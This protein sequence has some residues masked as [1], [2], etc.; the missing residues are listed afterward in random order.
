MPVN[1]PLGQVTTLTQNQLYGH[2]A[3][4]GN[5]TI[6]AD[7]GTGQETVIN[8]SADKYS[9]LIAV[10]QKLYL[11]NGNKLEQIYFGC[12]K[13]SIRAISH[14]IV[15]GSYSENDEKQFTY[16]WDFNTGKNIPIKADPEQ[17]MIMNQ[18]I[19]VAIGA[20]YTYVSYDDS[21]KK[22]TNLPDAIIDRTPVVIG[23]WVK[24]GFL[25]TLGDTSSFLNLRTGKRV[26]LD[27]QKVVV[28]SDGVYGYSD[29]GKTRQ[30]YDQNLS[31]V[32]PKVPLVCGS[33]ESSPRTSIETFA[34]VLQK[35]KVE[36]SYMCENKN[37]DSRVLYIGPEGQVVTRNETSKPLHIDDVSGAAYTHSDKKKF[38]YAGQFFI[39][40]DSEKDDRYVYEYGKVQ[41]IYY[42]KSGDIG[43]LWQQNHLLVL[44]GDKLRLIK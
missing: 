40:Y 38:L 3:E 20:G 8:L 17:I 5:I 29:D 44:D 13:C 33:L 36:Y 10:N 14:G 7:K 34:A 41:P 28:M 35:Y 24:V 43:V 42:E 16:I 11:L 4:A 25:D 12:P 22:L 6:P 9:N 18:Q 37:L 31:P 15:I 32:S 30:I 26:D 1:K 21:G 23:D 39:A 2:N 27:N 19:L